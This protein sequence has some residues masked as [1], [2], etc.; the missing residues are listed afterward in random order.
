MSIQGAAWGSNWIQRE[1]CG[2]S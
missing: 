2:P 1:M